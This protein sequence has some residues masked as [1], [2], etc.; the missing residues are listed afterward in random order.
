LSEEAVERFLH[1]PQAA[2]VRDLPRHLHGEPKP[3]RHAR[4]PA[5][6]GGRAVRSVEGGVDLDRGEAAGIAFEV[7]ARTGKAFRP[8]LR[9]RPTGATDADP[10]PSRCRAIPGGRAACG[11][12]CHAPEAGS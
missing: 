11:F 1:L 9:Y 2:P 8:R 6:V 3:L 12:L 4:R 5:R 7:T 10:G